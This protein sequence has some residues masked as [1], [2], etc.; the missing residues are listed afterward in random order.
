M[1]ILWFGKA[2]KLEDLNVKD[3]R[4]ERL[5]LEVQQD[6]L[7]S[8]MKRNQSEHDGILSAAAEPGLGDAEID[9]AAYKMEQALKRKGQAEGD[10]QQVI[11]RLQVIDS[12]IDILEQKKELEQKG[13]WKKINDLDEDKLREQLTSFA[14][15]RK[16]VRVSMNTLT[17]ILDLDPMDVKAQRS[18]EFRNNRATIEALRAKQSG[19]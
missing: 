9:I 15:Q 3:L 11:T 7:V 2:T 4:V 12:P 19:S 13:I 8:R 17:E 10:L 14:M 1:G 16:G 18:R 5:S 6:Q